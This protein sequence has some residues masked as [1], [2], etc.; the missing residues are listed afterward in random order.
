MKRKTK[1]VCTL[2]PITCSEEKIRQL[3]DAGMNVARLNGSHN[4]L[5]WHR[6]VIARVR[7]VSPLV[8][9][10][11]DIPGRKVRTGL[12]E[13]EIPLLKGRELVFSTD[14]IGPG[15]DKVPDTYAGLHTDLSAG[16]VI[17]ADDGTLQ[18]KVTAIR[19]KDIHCLIETDGVLRSSKGLNVPYVQL[20]GPVVSPRDEKMLAFA[21]QESVD[22]VGISF[23]ESAKH[24]E[25]IRKH[26][27]S[28]KVRI[29]SKIENKFGLNHLKEIT[30]ASDGLMIDRG[31]LGAETEIETLSV[32]QKTILREA[33][34]HSK[35]VIV[36]T[37]MLHTMIK[38]PQPTK[39]EVNDIS[40]AVFDGASAI[41][42]SGETAAGDFPLQ[43]VQT[44]NRIAS[45]AEDHLAQFGYLN[46]QS[47]KNSIPSAIARSIYEICQDMPVT[48]V[49]CLTASGFAAKMVSK[50][51]LK[52]PVIAVTNSAVVARQVN[53]HWGVQ[54]AL[55]D[56][57]FTPESSDHIIQSLEDL[58]RGGTLTMDDFIVVTAVKYPKQGL[59]M[60]TLEVYE[61]R[62][63]VD[64][65]KW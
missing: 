31:D 5:D 57:E 40:N 46:T 42:L 41:M 13:K 17:L 21:V 50:Y 30:L 48:K 27:A 29:V 63:L 45:S 11:F 4:T 19:G 49:V 35:P 58:Y 25:E 36:A 6:D 62:D 59:K 3:L 38:N 53:L 7:K 61:V 8:P 10:L 9:I 65:Q 44:M 56:V 15:S 20:K 37:E 22:F 12:L 52:Q 47:E 1:I 18:F 14:T 43:A 55:V 54:P 26:L 2:G 28:S 64:S 32:M 16:N 39:A 34:L 23:V 51:R 60:N 24:V 33:Q